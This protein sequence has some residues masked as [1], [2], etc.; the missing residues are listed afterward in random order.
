MQLNNIMHKPIPTDQLLNSD[1]MLSMLE[2][3]WLDS[4]FPIT[5]DVWIMAM[6]GDSDAQT[7]GIMGVSSAFTK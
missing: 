7:L 5:Y 6:V 1:Q 3:T 4:N 2:P